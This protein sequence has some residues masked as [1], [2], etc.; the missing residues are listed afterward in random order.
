MEERLKTWKADQTLG[1]WLDHSLILATEQDMKTC[2]CSI[3]LF[4]SDLILEYSRSNSFH[5][6]N[7]CTTVNRH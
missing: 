6:S 4:P 2:K 3:G 5:A 7:T 1:R